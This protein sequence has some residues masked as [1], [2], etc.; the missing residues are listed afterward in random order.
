MEHFWCTN[1]PWGNM[2]S[3][4]SPW[5]GLGGSHHLPP[6]SILCA[7]PQPAPKMLFCLGTLKLGVPKFPKL[8]LLRLWRLITSFAYFQSGWGLKQSCSPCWKL[9]NYMRH[10]TCTQVNQGDSQLS[11][12]RSQIGSLTPSLSFGHNLC[13][14]YPNGSCKPILDI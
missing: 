11:V 14:K 9:S 5:P 3:Q 1:E 6:Y 12:I 2:D 7:W 10:A 8:G 13:F 4:Y